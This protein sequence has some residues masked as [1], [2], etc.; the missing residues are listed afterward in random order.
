MRANVAANANFNENYLSSHW[1]FTVQLKA[2][3]LLP[4]AVVRTLLQLLPAFF[5]STSPSRRCLDASVVRYV[6]IFSALGRFI[7]LALSTLCFGIIQL[8]AATAMLLPS[9]F[10]QHCFGKLCM[11]LAYDVYA[12]RKSQLFGRVHEGRRFAED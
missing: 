8:R 11:L 5:A 1:V 9:Q 10:Q 12:Y 6:L 2:L 4:G 3:V 7:P